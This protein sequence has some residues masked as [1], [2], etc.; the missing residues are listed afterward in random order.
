[1][2]TT[3]RTQTTGDVRTITL[4][5]PER[6][7]ALSEL[8]IGDLAGALR[9]AER[10]E[11]VH[12]VILTGEDPAFC[13]GLDL[14][15]VRS[16]KL[17]VD[18][19]S[20]MADNPWEALARMRTPVIAAVN[21]ACVTAGLEL[22]LRCHFAIASDRARFADR[23]AEIG[24]HPGNGLTGLLPQVIGIRRARQL[25]LT[26]EFVTA[27]W[28][29]EMNLVNEVVAHDRLLDRVGE[30]ATLIAGHDPVAVQTL[31]DTYRQVSETTLGRG[32]ALEHRRF[33]EWPIDPE[34]I[35]AR[36]KADRARSSDGANG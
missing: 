18:R 20:E 11:T 7:N 32:L 28:A 29:L 30:L 4:A 35:A 33:R 24:I 25:S 9:A 15:D 17:D 13:A 16:R 26:G 31:N 10:D 21:G 27:G 34:A 23:H 2:E 22:M 36:V 8:L 5:R 19:L 14:D 6:R 12:C 1:M 3:L